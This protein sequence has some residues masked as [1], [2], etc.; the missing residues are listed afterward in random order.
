[1]AHD[2]KRERS[3]TVDLG[4][5]KSASD[6]ARERRTK[7]HL[8]LAS[9][10][11]FPMMPQFS[12][13][14][15]AVEKQ[16]E[17][18]TSLIERNRTEP[19][20][21]WEPLKEFGRGAMK[22]LDQIS[23]PFVAFS[24][25]ATGLLEAGLEAP[26]LKQV[27]QGLHTG[28]RSILGLPEE[29]PGRVASLIP[30]LTTTIETKAKTRRALRGIFDGSLSLADAAGS[31]REA[32]RTRTGWEQ[33]ILGVL[34]DPTTYVT[35]IGP[36]TH[37]GSSL[38]QVRPIRFASAAG[39]ASEALPPFA[40]FTDRVSKVS[41][42]AT[43]AYRGVT[44]QEANAWLGIGK[45]S[46]IAKNV[47]MTNDAAASLR[48]GGVLLEF[49]TTN[50]A[51]RVGKSK[52][53]TNKWAAG[54]AEFTVSKD[55]I[56]L[57]DDLRAV[58]I[59]GR[60][61]GAGKLQK[62]LD[63]LVKGDE[64]QKV[65]ADASGAVTYRR[66]T[67]AVPDEAQ[68]RA[69]APVFANRLGAFVDLDAQ[70]ASVDSIQTAIDAGKAR[71]ASGRK[72]VDGAEVR[73]T[74]IDVAD[75]RR[76]NA[77]LAL[78]RASLV[79]PTDAV[80]LT[81]KEWDEILESVTAKGEFAYW[82][83]R[84]KTLG[85]ESTKGKSVT[86]ER[87]A[88]IQGFPEVREAIEAF[89]AVRKNLAQKAP[90]GP[91]PAGR[92][93]TTQE[94][95]EAG[96]GLRESERLS[97]G[98][99]LISPLQGA[100][101]QA[102]GDAEIAK[103]LRSIRAHLDNE[104][105]EGLLDEA[106]SLG[107][108]EDFVIQVTDI[109][110]PSAL[111]LSV[112]KDKLTEASEAATQRAVSQA[113]TADEI[114][115]ALTADAI[116]RG[117]AKTGSTA[118][119]PRP[120]KASLGVKPDDLVFGWTSKNEQAA[121]TQWRKKLDEM[122]T[123]MQLPLP[124]PAQVRPLMSNKLLN[125]GVDMTIIQ[126]RLG[127]E[128]ITTTQRH[129]AAL[130][131]NTVDTD[132]IIER[133]SATRPN[134]NGEAVL[135]ESR[136]L[137]GAVKGQGRTAALINWGDNLANGVPLTADDVMDISKMSDALARADYEVLARLLSMQDELVAL[138]KTQQELAV[139]QL[140][141]K[142]SPAP[143]VKGQAALVKQQ[144]DDYKSIGDTLE[145]YLKAKSEEMALLAVGRGTN[146]VPRISRALNALRPGI[147]TERQTERLLNSTRAQQAAI[148]NRRLR[149]FIGPVG[150]LDVLRTT[151]D[152]ATSAKALT[153]WLKQD[154]VLAQLR[155]KG[156]YH[157]STPAQ[158][159]K[160]LT[161]AAKQTPDMFGPEFKNLD[162]A[163]QKA[164]INRVVSV[165][166]ENREIME[167]FDAKPLV[168]SRL[169]E[170]VDAAGGGG[171]D[172]GP[173]IQRGAE[174]DPDGIPNPHVAGD[175]IRDPMDVRNFQNMIKD[176]GR[177]K[178]LSEKIRKH[179]DFIGE[180]F[181]QTI[182]F[183][184][185]GYAPFTDRAGKVAL[186]LQALYHGAKVNGQVVGLSVTD[187]F[188]KAGMQIKRAT[189]P[190]GTLGNEYIAN[191]AEV[192][193]RVRKP[194][195]KM[196][197]RLDRLPE[198]DTGAKDQVMNDLNFIFDL[199]VS[200]WDEFY[201]FSRPEVKNA[202][203]YV[204]SI[205]DHA[206]IL[207]RKGGVHLDTLMG[208][209]DATRLKAYVPRMKIA[210]NGIYKPWEPQSRMVEQSRKSFFKPRGHLYY[211]EALEDLEVY[212]PVA[213]AVGIYIQTIHQLIG[214]Q[215]ATKLMGDILGT[216]RDLGNKAA[217]A[218]SFT[219]YAQAK[220]DGKV[221]DDMAFDRAKAQQGEEFSAHLLEV[222]RDAAGYLDRALAVG[223]EHT[224]ARTLAS[225]TKLVAPKADWLQ[226]FSFDPKT[227][228]ELVKLTERSSTLLTKMA[229][230]ASAPTQI[231]RVLK[232][233][234][235]IGAP[236]IFGLPLLSSPT[237]AG[238]WWK[239]YKNNIRTFIRPEIHAEWR[240]TPNVRTTMNEAIDHGVIFG[241]PEP[242]ER[243]ATGGAERAIDV[244]FQAPVL[245]R[246]LRRGEA[247]FTMF[248]EYSRV[249]LWD[250]MAPGIKA[251]GESLD[252]LAAVINKMTGT[253][254]Q[255]LSGVTPNMAIIQNALMFFAPVYRRASYGLLM[256]VTRGSK[257]RRTEAGKV[258][259]GML[260]TAGMFAGMSHI[261]EATRN[262]I[263]PFSDEAWKGGPLDPRTPEFMSLK[264]GGVNLGVG[265]AF[266]SVV[267]LGAGLVT[268]SL[269]AEKRDKLWSLNPRDNRLLRFVRGQTAPITGVG[270][271]F[272]TG[273]TFLGDPLRDENELVAIGKH[274]RQATRVV[275]PFW[276]DWDGQMYPDSVGDIV[277]SM[278]EFSGMR[279][280]P[281]HVM[282]RAN[283]ARQF[284]V[285]TST[286]PDI[287]TWR[288]DEIKAGRKPT[289]RN[290]PVLLK[291]QLLTD[292]DHLQRL[293]QEIKE[294]DLQRGPDFNKR[295]IEFRESSA[296]NRQLIDTFIARKAAAF[297]QGDIDG[298]QFGKHVREANVAMAQLVQRSQT[299]FDDVVSELDARRKERDT[300]DIAFQGDFFFDKYMELLESP[301]LHDDLGNF[302]I[303]EWRKNAN[304]FRDSAG[305]EIWNYIQRRLTSRRHQTALGKE[306]R[307]SKEVLGDYW[308]LADTIWGPGS[309]AA[310]EVGRYLRADQ[311]DRDIIERTL[312]QIRL[313]M[314]LLRRRREL[315]RIQNPAADWALVKF[316]G[317]TPRTEFARDELFK[318]K[319]HQQRANAGIDKNEALDILRLLQPGFDVNQGL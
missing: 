316:Y 241:R 178:H 191:A 149:K 177:L 187:T 158:L 250:A 180:K 279:A 13:N 203:L 284:Y 206:E 259:G 220:A 196:R 60:T 189:Y 9:R 56:T 108:F 153:G 148:A 127:H 131:H 209:R 282:E 169:D 194:H 181:E 315:F 147:L 68:A 117:L 41:D 199:E 32:N 207:A 133:L 110:D 115:D 294:N 268:D 138:R 245:G 176:S 141:Y 281:I 174:F 314:Q 12:D 311:F 83:P 121:V 303:A 222:D 16:F 212:A 22:L 239:A 52:S 255:A 313:W 103:R 266:Y 242:F 88:M 238:I 142:N 74:N 276:L 163:G 98:Q 184:G 54:I 2:E 272:I 100:R 135:G 47:Q 79:R 50:L 4:S 139:V 232:A 312:P 66:Q 82:L 92:K 288:A 307:E 97:K 286:D 244:V 262:G 173:L 96:G 70:K 318:W 310:D 155:F 101:S 235:D 21:R 38:L 35:G 99:G 71:I 249:S 309:L 90:T 10:G 270:I 157:D 75:I 263:D 61:L 130:G 201:E 159:R 132:D 122:R 154:L 297:E 269:D 86:F 205:V 26:G 167:F 89:I 218:K 172:F 223:K 214:E 104:G 275:T 7:G 292:T 182:E 192:G 253:Y 27:H 299:E 143:A 208:A 144:I 261:I 84:L 65:P 226:G 204:V 166:D 119:A 219:K 40:S 293:E 1:M 81:F 137:K 170:V 76:S 126:S 306:L 107:S 45:K 51:A 165:M 183:V 42:F 175:I 94:L 254:N 118:K 230:I 193:L 216:P 179:S 34:L 301:A 28:V 112:L 67:L 58:L 273:R 186:G 197:E 140:G 17:E 198:W 46:K 36:L 234:I 111:P 93:F 123:E 120:R 80:N 295:V 231:S 73:L 87:A 33:F 6:K 317:A 125:D 247:A 287:S 161:R 171:D 243:L 57:P 290:M 134:L 283:K 265:A 302:D 95:V 185:G 39:R 246:A 305:E 289:W 29:T 64:W 3:R 11:R 224:D 69:M 190:N 257:T 5:L 114:T 151:D 237:K 248:Q 264:I 136:R 20:D 217:R 49:D 31:L 291:Q 25:G 168:D 146:T 277:Q 91:A 14:T 23:L 240:L 59:P 152:M 271:D 227:A 124:L 319:T 37:V 236:L 200:K 162:E 109:D 256:D 225:A 221:Y 105:K 308:G 228:K 267:R 145:D 63:N 164:F 233:G 195:A 252:D 215:Q 260:V 213:D 19:P 274:V 300:T 150:D 8:D 18:L 298:V 44:V 116:E 210:Q 229:D 202:L 102:E 280:F 304:A 278:G 113:Q 211:D 285:N 188:V 258:L 43:E 62:H 30:G 48:K 296:E 72:T 77:I 78:H 53:T 55:V 106:G 85:G 128:S 24:E 15:Q 129:Y 251:R 160:S 156:I